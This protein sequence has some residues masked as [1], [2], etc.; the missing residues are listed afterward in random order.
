[1]N[2][3]TLDRA[4]FIVPGIMISVTIYFVMNGIENTTENPL[5]NYFFYLLSLFFSVLYYAFN[6]RDVIW[7]KLDNRFFMQYISMCVD[8]IKKGEKIPTP[9]VSCL[10]HQKPN[11][12]DN[13]LN[14]NRRLFFE[15][16]DKQVVLKEKSQQVMLNGCILTSVID[17]CII[18][19][20]VVL[21][22]IIF[23][24]FDLGFDITVLI[25]CAVLILL[26]PIVV[27]R[28]TKKHLILIKSQMNSV[29]KDWL[30][31]KTD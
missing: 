20:A 10:F 25:V 7:R 17:L 12:K 18:C 13:N 2:K 28:L 27:Y 30:D 1:M 14:T 16:I 6:I 23:Y 24:H 9:C 5:N 15:V 29:K 8:N 31:G 19:L 4:R 26:T 11:N 21:V 3:Q 22:E